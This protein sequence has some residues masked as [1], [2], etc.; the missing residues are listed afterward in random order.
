M[1]LAILGHFELWA[2]SFFPLMFQDVSMIP[3]F[4]PSFDW[5]CFLVSSCSS[6][7]ISSGSVI[8]VDRSDSLQKGFVLSWSDPSCSWLDSV[9]SDSVGVIC[10]DL[11]SPLLLY[12]IFS[13]ILH[14]NLIL[15]A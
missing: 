11:I 2:P 4:F 6:M 7:F 15:P 10:H 9:V 12:F 5:N 3:F 14:I 8:S 13:F 1:I